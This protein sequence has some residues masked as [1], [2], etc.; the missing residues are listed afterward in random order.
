MH[1][2]TQVCLPHLRRI[3]LSNYRHIISPS[4]HLKRSHCL[5][6][7]APM[8][9]SVEGIGCGLVM[10]AWLRLYAVSFTETNCYLCTTRKIG[11]VFG[12]GVKHWG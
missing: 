2:A 5:T 3:M 6:S 10:H 12:E 9:V 7:V 8:T 1:V 11:R 4:L